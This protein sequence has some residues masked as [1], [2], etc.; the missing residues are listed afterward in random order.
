L[1]EVHFVRGPRAW[2]SAGL[3]NGGDEEGISVHSMLCS[4]RYC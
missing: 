4:D 1:L 2:K 3:K